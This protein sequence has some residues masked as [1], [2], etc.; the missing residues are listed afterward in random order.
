[1]Y[2]VHYVNKSWWMFWQNCHLTAPYSILVT[3]EEKMEVC[4]GFP[5]RSVPV[6]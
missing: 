6:L 3:N 2:K 5:Y 4:L 1:M